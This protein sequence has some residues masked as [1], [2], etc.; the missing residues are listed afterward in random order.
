VNALR[1]VDISPPGLLDC[2]MRSVASHHLRTY[3]ESIAGRTLRYVT[4]L[5]EPVLRWISDVRYFGR[6]NVADGKPPLTLREYVEWMLDQ[7]A[8]E[9]L[10]LVNGQTNF[11]AEHEWFRREREESACIDWS[12]E[13]DL[14]ARYARERLSLALDLLRSFPVVGTVERLTDFTRVL[15]ARAPVWD[16]PLLPVQ[17]V[18]MTLVTTAPPVDATWIGPHDSVGRRLLAAFAEDFELHRVASELIAAEAAKV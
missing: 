8:A 11:I 17:G 5:R 6:L 2:R 14:F 3:P 16:V 9:M 15:Q 10:H 12:A 18:E 1:W 13:P 7:P 4:L